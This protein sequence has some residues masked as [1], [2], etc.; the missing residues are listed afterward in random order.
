MVLRKYSHV[1]NYVCPKKTALP[2]AFC[3]IAKNV[4]IKSL[5][6]HISSVHLDN[7]ECKG[8]F[9]FSV[10]LIFFSNLYK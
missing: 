4:D 9:T 7:F 10:Q 2:A 6:I 5:V 1:K 8:T 3:V